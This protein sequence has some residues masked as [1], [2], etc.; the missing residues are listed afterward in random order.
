MQNFIMF[1]GCLSLEFEMENEIVIYQPNNTI[2][3][4]VRMADESV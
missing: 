1:F 3:L 4:E 2:H